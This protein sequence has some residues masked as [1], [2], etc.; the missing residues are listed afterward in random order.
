[1]VPPAAAQRE[2]GPWERKTD[3]T[4]SVRGT[5][6]PPGP[7]R[8][9]PVHTPICPRGK[10]HPRW[11]RSGRREGGRSSR[12]GGG[13]GKSPGRG[14]ERPPFQPVCRTRCHPLFLPAAHTP[15]TNTHTPTR[16][17]R[18]NSPAAAAT[19]A[20]RGSAAAAPRGHDTLLGSVRRTRGLWQLRLPPPP[21]PPHASHTPE[22]RA[23]ARPPATA[24]ARGD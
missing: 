8:G 6:R 4:H 1:M 14:Q 16:A 22:S 7:S 9:A 12:Q 24:R 18:I 13:S 10:S 5:A 11:P 2:T 15:N 20:R 23:P 19:A 17:S 21:S 3:K